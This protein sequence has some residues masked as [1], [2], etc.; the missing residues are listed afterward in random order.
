M[1]TE[2][3]LTSTTVF[4]FRI[5]SCGSTEQ[6]R[7]ASHPAL[8][9]PELNNNT[10][11]ENDCRNMKR[12][13]IKERGQQVTR[14]RRRKLPLLQTM[15]LLGLTVANIRH[16]LVDATNTPIEETHYAVEESVSPD[17]RSPPTSDAELENEGIDEGDIIVVVAVDGTLAGISKRSGKVLWKHS[18]DLETD[19]MG[20][21]K[22]TM[23]P[24]HKTVTE[25]LV[26]PLISTT[27]TT[28]AASSSS[29]N[30]A[31][32]PSLD[33]NVFMSSCG[34]TVKNSVKELVSRSPFL[35]D[36]GQFFVGSRHSTAAAL[37][38][39]TGEVLRLIPPSE[40]DR[41][42]YP[43][44]SFKGRNPVWIGRV[45]Y[46]V[47]VQDAKTGTTEVQFSAAEV[48]SV[49]EMQ[50]KI[51]TDAWKP[52]KAFDDEGPNV[53]EAVA[54]DG[55]ERVLGQS[56]Q[57]IVPSAPMT[58][59]LSP[60]VATPGGN[61][62][63][64]N[65]MS[66]ILEWVSDETFSSPVV[67]AIDASSGVRVEVDI[68]P[69]VPVPGSSL[70][71]LSR[72]I[73][74]QLERLDEQ[75]TDD[76]T[77][78]GALSN[79][80]LYA[81]H[82]GSRRILPGIPSQRHTIAS[83]SVASNPKRLS[84]FPQIVGRP[85]I[86]HDA[87]HVHS[88]PQDQKQLITTSKICNPA[89][90]GFP[91]CLLYTRAKN[92]FPK[93]QTDHLVREG[94]DTAVEE[95]SSDGEDVAIAASKLPDGVFFHPEYGYISPQHRRPKYRRYLTMG[96]WL[97]P[98]LAF[99]FVISFE[100]GRRKRQKDN[101]RLSRSA[102][103]K[104][105]GVGEVVWSDAKPTQ[106][107]QQ[108]VIQVSDE[109]L[110]YGGQG[111]VVYK[112]KLDGR[113]VAVK[114]L[115]KAY[116]AG[117]DREISLLIE[118][119]G[120][121][122]V[123]RYFL[124]EIRGD[125]VYLALEL[126]DL[127][128][129]D[130]IVVLRQHHEQQTSVSGNSICSPT[131]FVLQ[132]IA[133]GVKHLHSL[134]IVHRDLKPQNILLATSKKKETSLQ[135]TPVLE[136]FQKGLYIAKI[137]DMG[138]GKQ[139]SGQSSIGVSMLGESNRGSKPEASSVGVGPGS[140]G[141][142]APEVMALKWTSDS[143]ARSD[144]SNGL[145]S[146]TPD[147]A[148]NEA[149]PGTR[150]S[151]SVDI[152]SLGCIFYSTIV[153]GHH[154]FGEW[155]E[156]ES[157]IMRNRPALHS[158]KK[159][160]PDA[161][162]LVRA[163]LR[164]NP[165][166][167]PTAKEICEHPFFWDPQ[168]RLS[169]L[170]DVSDRLETDDA[171][172]T[173]TQTKSTLAIERG[174]V[175]VVGTAWDGRLDDALISNVQK[176]RSYDPSSL[177]DLLRLIRNKHHHF[178]EL[179]DDFRTST[180]S[181]QDEMLQYFE[182]RFP[183][184]LMHCFH[185][186]ERHFGED[187]LLA[188]KYSIVPVRTQERAPQQQDSMPT[189]SDLSRH[190]SKEA[191]QSQIESVG[192]STES[193]WSFQPT[194][195][196]DSEEPVLRPELQDG[197]RDDIQMLGEE[198]ET[199]S[200]LT[201]ED[202]LPTATDSDDIIAWEGSTAARTFNCRGWSRSE[203]EWSNRIDPFFRKRGPNLKRAAEDPKFRTRLCNHWDTNLGTFCPMRKKSK[204]IFAH[205]PVELRVKEGKIGRWGKLV[206]KHGNNSNPCHSGGEDT[207]GAAR[208]IESVRKVEGKWNTSRPNGKKKSNGTKKKNSSKQQQSSLIT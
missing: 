183:S 17:I 10:K 1:A 139:L 54:I 107:S 124:K 50:G 103:R 140:V 26:R 192:L 190:E 79:G 47:D 96:L 115:L 55:L 63:Y 52:M 22:H 146:S 151:R 104:V 39:T 23:K 163:M 89:S 25:G 49:A 4:L 57:F 95:S 85:A 149:T 112:G 150:T 14:R 93:E 102:V 97:P 148:S 84:N 15:L 56:T 58:S 131:K 176:F 171:T 167:R 199:D 134:R 119:D 37:D 175:E 28:K 18:R 166:L 44:T 114:R 138:L 65:T 30:F 129:H 122:N 168:K 101:Q 36:D 110:G 117:A 41:D 62:A 98:A 108:C 72:E 90:Q 86:H 70:E 77:I 121:P 123:V 69:D 127:S 120:H 204:C 155:Y 154:P 118:S 8:V 33:G 205:G 141:W 184:L 111:T 126:C 74:K 201:A 177:R 12:Q 113:D 109:I 130:L 16:R 48:I 60:L 59:E 106:V 35:N 144:P 7:P 197:D 87:V 133:S 40:M 143:S 82:L 135:E 185:H 182:E 186:C 142:Q 67:F 46:S 64:R 187:D 169:F 193:G 132:Q 9:K 196:N 68:I 78:V 161:H 88:R 61:I 80:Q 170:C 116:Q 2:W 6:Q 158:L 99:I 81:L 83:T 160:S 73:E 27:T 94:S 19:E 207:Y 152:F 76:Q 128:L 3:I 208:S 179:P 125:F 105:D 156:R 194:A 66:G 165:K 195:A 11:I 180:M 145:P 5:E 53:D 45:D 188:I 13:K 159:L 34:E 31:A 21:Q 20:Y 32:V 162:D 174:A 198:I 100:L 181:N 75:A 164:Q 153:P 71:Y 200:L 92:Y 189:A 137:S 43:S 29:T 172:E 24:R 157:N 136:A 191:C 91:A 51:G 206:D 173:S 38:A 147:Q 202:I 203:D 178:D 42:M